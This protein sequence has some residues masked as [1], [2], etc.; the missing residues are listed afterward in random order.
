MSMGPAFA[1]FQQ[2]LKERVSNPTHPI[3]PSTRRPSLESFSGMFI[4]L[5]NLT[6]FS[7]W[8]DEIIIAIVAYV[9]SMIDAFA[10]ILKYR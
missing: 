4:F 8:I 5:D 3:N 1:P 10:Y 9:L 7:E 6:V 2:F